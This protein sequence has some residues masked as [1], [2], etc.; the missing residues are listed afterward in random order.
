MDLGDRNPL[1]DDPGDH[2]CHDLGDL[3]FLARRRHPPRGAVGGW[4][5]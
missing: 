2:R 5:V 3:H 4:E 1:C